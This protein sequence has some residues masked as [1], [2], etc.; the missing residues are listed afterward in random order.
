[1]IAHVVLDNE[2]CLGACHIRRRPTLKF[3][4]C[5]LEPDI[6]NKRLVIQKSQ[7]SWLSVQV[8]WRSAPVKSALAGYAITRHAKMNRTF[9]ICVCL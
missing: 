1:M 5:A 6:P 4:C 7:M 8:D 2:A 3:P 9:F